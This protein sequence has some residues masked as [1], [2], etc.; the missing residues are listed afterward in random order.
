MADIDVVPKHRSYVWLWIVLAV[1]VA[2]LVIWA[3]MGRP[4]PVA[5]LY[6]PEPAFVSHLT[7]QDDLPRM[8]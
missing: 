1:I 5:Q 8:L 3:M 7:L 4:R 6:P 2:G